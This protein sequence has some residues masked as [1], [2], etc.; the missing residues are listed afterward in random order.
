MYSMSSFKGAAAHKYACRSSTYGHVGRGAGRYAL[1]QRE[2]EL[3][4][5]G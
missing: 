4:C 5:C 2:G 1:R 3:L